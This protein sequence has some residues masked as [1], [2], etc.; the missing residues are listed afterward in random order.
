[1]SGIH[2]EEEFDRV[3]DK[4][5]CMGYRSRV[6]CPPLLVVGENDQLD[7]LEDKLSLCEELAGPKEMW[8][9]EDDSHGSTSL[10]GLAGANPKPLMADWLKDTLTGKFASDYQKLDS[11][12]REQ[13]RGPY[14]AA[15]KCPLGEEFY[16]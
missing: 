15:A 1:M 13:G 12:P 11:V 2:E 9:M 14:G 4:M 6:A 10:P 7:F 5:T 16:F 8:L 3:A